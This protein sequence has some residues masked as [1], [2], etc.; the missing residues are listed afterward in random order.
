VDVPTRQ[1]RH[2][3]KSLMMSNHWGV[4]VY[5]TYCSC[6]SNNVSNIRFTGK[7]HLNQIQKFLRGSEDLSSSSK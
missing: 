2:F 7:N 4:S 5:V 3:D 1:W 6:S